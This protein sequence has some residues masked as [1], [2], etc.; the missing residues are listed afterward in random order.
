MGVPMRDQGKCRAPEV[1][2]G[3]PMLAPGYMHK[4]LLARFISMTINGPSRLPLFGLAALAL[5]LGL[6][7]CAGEGDV[8]GPTAGAG[9]VDTRSTAFPGSVIPAVGGGAG[10][11]GGVSGRGAVAGTMGG[12]GG[13]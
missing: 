10:N 13:R 4:G 9:S 2:A 5:M 1:I 12:T 11:G 7:A 8:N 3:S 6:G